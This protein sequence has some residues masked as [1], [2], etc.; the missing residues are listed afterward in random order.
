M[1]VVWS[2][3]GLLALSFFVVALLYS[4]AGFGG[5]SSYLALLS[6]V[7]TSFFMI[8]TTA[9]VCNLLVVSGSCLLFYRAGALQLKKGLPFIISSI[10]LAYI[11]AQFKLEERH[12]FI[13]LGG[14]LIL[15]AALL[16]FQTFLHKQKSSSGQYPQSLSYLIGAAVGLLSGLVGI[17]GGIF[18][19]PILHYLKWDKA[20]S[21]AAL[22]SFFILAN[23]LAGIG[24]LLSS[25]TFTVFWPALAVLMGA[26]LLGGQVG[27][28]L[29][30]LRIPQK[31]IRLI[32][33]IL[34]FGVGLRLLINNI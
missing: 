16:I 23:S 3:I 34:V 29:S 20:R 12:F 19:A 26:V 4:A 13:L 14:A 24:G 2:E 10:P 5:G 18:L 1:A 31:G 32:T 6:L 15:A 11:G 27:V 33:A 7:F 9:L 17:G 30:I 21:I 22:A 8:R 25:G 28:R